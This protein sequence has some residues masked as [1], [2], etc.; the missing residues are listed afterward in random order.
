MEN[1]MKKIGERIKALRLKQEWSQQDLAKYTGIS[2]SHIS[3]IERGE[4][5][6]SVTYLVQLANAFRIP[7]DFLLRG[8]VYTAQSAIVV[9]SNIIADCSMAEIEVL[10]ET[11]Y[12]LKQNLRKH[13]L[14]AM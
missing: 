11:T 4:S 7:T 13:M 12:N 6:F 9:F 2:A 1:Q 8:E 14:E 5:D 3:S 10:T